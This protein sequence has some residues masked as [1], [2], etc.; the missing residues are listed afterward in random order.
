[1]K[2][3]TGLKCV[4]YCDQRFFCRK[5]INCAWHQVKIKRDKNH[6]FINWLVLETLLASTYR[7]NIKPFVPNAGFLNPLRTSEN[8][9]VI[10]SGGREREYCERMG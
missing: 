4:K 3:N 8:C 10:L 1:M 9:K 6:Q 2:S 5:Q 7:T